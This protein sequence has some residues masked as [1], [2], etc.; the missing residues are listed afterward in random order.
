M[1]LFDRPALVRG[2]V[3]ERTGVEFSTHAPALGSVR[4]DDLIGGVVYDNHRDGWIEM[5]CAGEPGWLTRQKLRVFFAYP[6]EQLK[7]RGV[8]AI[9]R[10]RNKAAR[11]LIEGLGWKRPYCVP[12]GFED[13]DMILYTMLRRECRWLG[14]ND[15]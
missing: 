8:L 13:D 14:G 12:E 3:E 1:M 5:H 11:R 2:W 9:V 7:C 4:G 15:G 10:R 6:F